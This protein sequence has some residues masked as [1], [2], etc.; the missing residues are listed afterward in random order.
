MTNM[1]TPTSRIHQDPL[2]CASFS[3]GPGKASVYRV[4]LLTLPV[5]KK[6]KRKCLASNGREPTEQMCSTTP[7]RQPLERG[8][9]SREA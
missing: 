3:A 5:G 9:E 6:A 7:W 8:R 1:Y 2:S 4:R